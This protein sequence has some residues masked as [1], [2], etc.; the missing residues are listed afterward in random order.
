M[1]TRWIL[2]AAIG[3]MAALAALGAGA[4]DVGP[5]ISGRIHDEHGRPVAGATVELY[6]GLATRFL[7]E[8]AAT[9]ER[10]EYRFGPL[11]SGTTIKNEAANRWD[12]YFGI[13]VKHPT[14]A[15]EDG[16]SWRD[17]QVP[18]VAGY[19]FV[20]DFTMTTGGTMVG[21]VTDANGVPA[22][23]LDLRLYIPDSRGRAGVF[24][25]YTKTDERGAFREAGLYPGSYVIDINGGAQGYPKI[26]ETT[27]EAQKEAGVR[28]IRPSK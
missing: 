15:P 1:R 17:I 5:T 28:L 18:G 11:K 10:G 2:L 22:A 26:G 3:L 13:Q 21:T 4:R 24:V 20:R 16:R 9:D 19:E 7:V 25:R 14:L 12:Y 6:G 27:V 8:S 23:S